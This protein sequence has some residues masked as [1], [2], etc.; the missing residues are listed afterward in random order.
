[1]IAIPLYMLAGVIM[2]KSGITAKIF[3]FANA[4]ISHFTGGLAHVN[5]LASFIFSGMSGSELADASGLGTVEIKAM[6]DAGYDKEFSEAVTAGSETIGP[7]FPPSIPMVIIGSV[8]GISIGKLFVG[9]IIPGVIL[10]IYLLLANFVISKKRGYPKGDSFSGPR[11]WQTFKEALPALLTPIIIVGGILVGVFTST[12]AGVVA[13]LYALLVGF[14]VYREVK[15][16][17]LPAL[18]VGGDNG[19]LQGFAHRRRG[20]CLCLGVGQRADR[21]NRNPANH[22][23]KHQPLCGAHPLSWACFW[24][25]AVS[26]THRQTSSFSSPCLCPWWKAWALIPCI[27]ESWPTLALMLGLITPPLGLCMFIICGIAN[28]TILQFTKAIMPTLAALVLVLITMMYIPEVV[29]W[30]PE[31]VLG[32]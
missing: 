32:K 22:L 14:L 9:G 30:L 21:R 24:W 20:V 4:L 5:V 26:S 8:A 25:P 28:I 23:N 2:N 12:E 6:V 17:D 11:L 15:L 18:L 7:I 1:M 29:T 31:V 27:S 10:A 19:D 13:V 3:N 16:G